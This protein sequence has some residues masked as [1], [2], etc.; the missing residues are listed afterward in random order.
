LNQ[1][2]H[3]FQFSGEDVAKAALNER[4]YH[5]SR[6][7]HW[8]ERQQAAIDKAK[9]LTAIV[10]VTEYPVTGGKRVQVVADITGVQE[11]NQ[12]LNLAS[13]KIDAHRKM[14]DEYNL[15][16]AAYATQGKRAYELDPGDVQYFRLAGGERPE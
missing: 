13:E 14:A 2:K 6:L 1:D 15:K 12:E 3:L 5:K 4:D 8:R 11:I 16:A 7:D 9:G 10:K